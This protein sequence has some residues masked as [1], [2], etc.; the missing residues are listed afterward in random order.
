MEN[1]PSMRYLTMPAVVFGDQI[2][3]SPPTNRL[4]H[5]EI[6][7]PFV[8]YKN[9]GEQLSLDPNHQCSDLRK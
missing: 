6:F 5:R 4:L 7:P 2:S 3:I 9:S 1:K 8:A